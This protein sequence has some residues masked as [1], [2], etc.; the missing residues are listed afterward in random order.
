MKCRL[1]YLVGQLSA[2]GQE[3][4]LCNLF[5]AMDRARYR[6]AVAVWNFCENDLY[7]PEVR[8][9]GVPIYPFSPKSTA[10]V[11]IRDFRCLVK[12]LQPQIV[13]SYSYYL[14]VVAYWSVRGIQI[15][16][17]GSVRGDFLLDRQCGAWLGR[18]NGFL[19]RNQIFNNFRAAENARQSK[20]LF[21]PGQ[22]FVVQ[23][24]VDSRRFKMTPLPSTGR[25]CIVGN[26]SLLAYKRWPRLLTAAHALKNKGLEFTVRI[27]GDGPE[28]PRL[29]Q[30]V[31]DLQLTED[32]QFIRRVDDVPEFLA[33]A[34]FLVHTSETEGC[35]NVVIEAMACG[36]PVIATDA[37]D[38]SSL[39]DHGRTGFVI[40]NGDD[41]ALVSHMESLVTDRDLCRRMGEMARAKAERQFN[42]DRLVSETFAAYRAA[43]W[44]DS[45]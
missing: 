23:N 29:L 2:G 37:G 45:T 36:R 24:G 39:V 19:P 18:L 12:K 9:L 33:N 20:S 1:L 21:V 27:V 41:A 38:V 14:N 25:A 17:I 44:R 40:P 3:R 30:Q 6:P 10:R 28:L 15:V 4:Q 11:K 22:I 43:G 42:L 5:Q 31:R 8:R 34:T 32:V 26:G 16:P 7:L 35:P 13:H